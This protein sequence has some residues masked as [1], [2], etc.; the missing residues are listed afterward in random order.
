[1]NFGR[2]PPLLL[3]PL[4]HLKAEYLFTTVIVDSPNIGVG[5]PDAKTNERY[6]YTYCI[7]T[8][9]YTN[10][11]ISC[12]TQFYIH[13]GSNHKSRAL[14]EIYITYNFVLYNRIVCT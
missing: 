2:T 14:Y 8:V 12:R 6:I 11:V 1:M 9:L 3:Y 7:D 4:L 10:L 13:S 5:V